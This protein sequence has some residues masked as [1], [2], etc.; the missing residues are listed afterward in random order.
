MTPR[1]SL[2]F[3]N[4][5]GPSELALGQKP[6]PTPH[7]LGPIVSCVDLEPQQGPSSVSAC[8]TQCLGLSV[9]GGGQQMGPA[10]YKLQH[11][12]GT[13]SGSQSLQPYPST[14][15]SRTLV[16]PTPKCTHPSLSLTRTRYTPDAVC[17]SDSPCRCYIPQVLPQKLQP[18]PTPL[19]S[20]ALLWPDRCRE[21][22]LGGLSLAA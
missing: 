1:S 20:S 18:M 19:I 16:T 17:L 4:F 13:A 7:Q 14:V 3:S 15:S 21:P 9:G 10:F 8:L 2:N 22:F 5:L 6:L 12:L 11:P